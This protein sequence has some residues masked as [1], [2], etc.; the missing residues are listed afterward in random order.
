[1]IGNTYFVNGQIQTELPLWLALI[2]LVLAIFLSWLAYTGKK[3]AELF[4]R[5]QRIGLG[6]LR[7]IGIFML[8]VLMLGFFF[9][10]VSKE[11]IRQSYIVLIDNSQSMTV[12][13]D[14]SEIIDEIR[15]LV[16]IS[17]KEMSDQLIVDTYTI[18][19][20]LSSGSFVDFQEPVTNFTECFDQLFL[21]YRTRNVREVL[22]ITDGIPTTGADLKFALDQW[23]YPVS[24]V[25]Y[26]DSSIG[27]DTRIDKVTVSDIAYFSS[28]F[29]VEFIFSSDLVGGNPRSFRLTRDSVTIL[30]TTIQLD[31][32]DGKG[33]LIVNLLADKAGL[34]V[35][36]ATVEA[37]IDELN[38]V[39]NSK[40]FVVDVVERRNKVLLIYDQP[41]PDISLISKVMNKT[42]D[43]ELKIWPVSAGLPNLDEYAMVVLYQ[44]PGSDENSQSIVS[45]VFSSQKNVLFFVGPGTSISRLNDNPYGLR[46]DAQ[47]V[48]NE[49][50]GAHINPQFDL[51]QLPDDLQKYIEIVPPL[52]S[53]MTSIQSLSSANI[54]LRQSV[55]GI[56]LS[57]PLIWFTRSGPVKVGYFWGE[58]IW[59][60]STFEYL[61]F[62]DTFYTNSLIRS[63]ISYLSVSDIDDPLKVDVPS[64]VSSYE[65]VK[66]DARLYN[67]SFELT[68]EPN[69][70]MDLK[71]PDGEWRK[72]EYRKTGKSYWLELE[73][74]V[75]GKYEYQCYVNLSG[76]EI[77]KSGILEVMEIPYEYLDIKARIS[78]MKNIAEKKGGQ[79]F[80]STNFEEIKEYFSR[81]EPTDNSEFAIT[82]WNNLLDWQ[83]LLFIIVGIFSLEWILRRYMGTR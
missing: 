9:K 48:V 22:L 43:Y 15:D 34:N 79:H 70:Y 40:S 2:G 26:G 75:K 81:I 71:A 76:Q 17:E 63:L 62:E 78:E 51:F 10:S 32:I 80:R 57:D 35:F 19:E 58:G 41:H 11:L 77:T 64:F 37:S 69:L 44:L 33:Q 23:P 6:L 42:G 16:S 54:L 1:M 49:D 20:N 38:K 73:N 7:G 30:D 14:T 83:I 46:A 59:R 72:F 61:Y 52:K 68:N 5:L 56:H 47:R 74:L 53:R 29:P 8:F 67:Q 3:N 36:E 13:N 45:K 82:K 31:P 24:F 27:E 25:S 4:T 50:I 21:K 66:W 55:K 39:N 65:S 18:G 28:T 60:W 12:R